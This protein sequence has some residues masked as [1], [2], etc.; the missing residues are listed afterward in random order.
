MMVDT[1]LV[2]ECP[3]SYV[4]YKQTLIEKYHTS[5]EIVIRPLCRMG[6][7]ITRYILTAFLAEAEINDDT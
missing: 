6:A 4:G 1:I 5:W 3:F 2:S 7:P